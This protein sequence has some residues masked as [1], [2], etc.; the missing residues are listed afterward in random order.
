MVDNIS[1]LHRSTA[2]KEA[3]RQRLEKSFTHLPL[4]ADNLV[5]SDKYALELFNKIANL[6]HKIGRDD[7]LFSQTLSRYC[8]KS[9]ELRNITFQLNKIQDLLDGESDTKTYNALLKSY[10]DLTKASNTISQLLLNLEKELTLTPQSLSR[11]KLP[12]PNQEETDF[13]LD[14]YILHDGIDDLFE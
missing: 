14:D 12:I 1:F 11:C 10:N 8:L 7:K 13:N 6:L 2:E 4:E 9:S 3:I 5:K